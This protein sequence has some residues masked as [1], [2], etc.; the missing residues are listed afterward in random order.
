ML[1]AHIPS[2]YVIAKAFK[3]EKKSVVASSL[4]FSVLPD[5]GLIYYYLIDNS[6]SH[7]HFFPHLPIVM[8]SVFLITLPLYR[9]KLFEKMR[10]YYV[11][12]FANWLTHLI[13]DTF[14][15][16]IFWF[17]PLSNHG[18]QLI[19]IPA[20]FNHWIISFVFHWSFVAE[21][22]IVTFTL[23]LFLRSRKRKREMKSCT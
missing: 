6:V 23:I 4:I 9:M 18:F 7:R 22:V 8:A 13:L 1:I 11:L 14:T 12:F 15:E 3:Q 10:I 16:R 21:L 19:E 20:V 2:G 5:L 17:Y